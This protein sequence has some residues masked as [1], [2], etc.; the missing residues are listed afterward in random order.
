MGGHWT[1]EDIDTN[2]MDGNYMD[3]P[4]NGGVYGDFFYVVRA[5][6]AL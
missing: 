6:A 3:D 4:A 2:T 5:P 1:S